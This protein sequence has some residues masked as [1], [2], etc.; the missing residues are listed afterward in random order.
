MKDN[1]RKPISKKIRFEIFKR[2]SF[3]CQYCSNK[4][5]EVILEVDHIIPVS[6]GGTNDIDNLTTSC[7]NCNR[8][9]GAIELDCVTEKTLEK[10]ERIKIALNQYKDFKKILNKKEL[11][12]KKEVSE[13]ENVYS[14]S[15]DNFE[16]SEKFKNSVKIFIQRIG[17]FEVKK[18]MEKSCSKINN[19]QDALKYFC[20]ICWNL[21]K[22]N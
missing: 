5:P 6:K 13:I 19:E 11:E 1:T 3:T 9:K 2:D 22:E 14:L 4:S 18:A 12:I 17:F 8:G 16:F 10:S 15:F 21:I 20:G 7:Y